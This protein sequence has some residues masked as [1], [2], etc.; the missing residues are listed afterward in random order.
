MTR[1]FDDIYA[2]VHPKGANCIVYAFIDGNKFDLLDSGAGASIILSWLRKKM[3]KDGLDPFNI[4]IFF[5][6]MF[7]MITL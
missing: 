1:I 7:I 5:I 6:A 2:Y 3:I 4:R